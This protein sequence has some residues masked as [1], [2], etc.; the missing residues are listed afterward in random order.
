MS[1]AAAMTGS[2]PVLAAVT[3]ALAAELAV[4]DPAALPAVMATRNVKPTSESP[5]AYVVDV[6]PPTGAQLSPVLSQRD[7]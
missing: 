2:L 7:H 5:G 3:D 4:A 1:P 6:A